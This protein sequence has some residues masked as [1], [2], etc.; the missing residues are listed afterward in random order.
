[1]HKQQN[2]FTLIEI[3]VTIAILGILASVAFPLTP[4]TCE[5]D[6]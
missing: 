5:E 4:I 1:M 2:G 3:L 6:S